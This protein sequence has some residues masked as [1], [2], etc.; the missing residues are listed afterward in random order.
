MLAVP[1]LGREEDAADQVATY[2]ATQLGGD[3]AERM[4]RAAAFMYEFSGGKTRNCTVA[5]LTRTRRRR[6]V[7]RRSMP[8]NNAT[9]VD[10]AQRSRNVRCDATG[11]GAPDR[12]PSSA[13][14][15]NSN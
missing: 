11:V 10:Q 15:F 13:I 6:V 14:H 5:G 12:E 9:T 4:L 1:V 7:K 8:T 3:F 2:A